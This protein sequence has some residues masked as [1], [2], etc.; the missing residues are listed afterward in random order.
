VRERFAAA[1]ARRLDTH[2]PRIEA[3]L[4]V[5][6]EDAIL[7]QHVALRRMAF[8]V[9]VERAAPAVDR[10]VVDHRD[11]GRGDALADAARKGTRSLAVEVASSP[12][13]IASCSRM[14]G[15]PCPSTTV[16]VPAWRVACVEIEQRLAN[17]LRHV[18]L[19]HRVGEVA[20]VAAPSAAGVT[21]LPA[22]AVLHDH[23]QRDPHERPNVGSDDAVASRN[24]HRL[25]FAGE[26]S[27]HLAHARVA[28]ARHL[29]EAFEQRDL[30]FFGNEATGSAGA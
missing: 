28:L 29:L 15:H 25:V 17:R 14:P 18:R 1:I 4:H 3:V 10:P 2:Q 23:R 30:G 8:V 9:D 19:E 13:P 12:C 16:I 21:L 26:R 20:V 11:A 5:A 22:A 27:H 6:L 7:D 24:E